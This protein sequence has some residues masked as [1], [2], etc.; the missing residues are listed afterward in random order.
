MLTHDKMFYAENGS[1]DYDDEDDDEDGTNGS[2]STV[3]TS[4]I[5]AAR[6]TESSSAASGGQASAPVACDE[7]HF[8]EKWFHGKLGSKTGESGR[9][10]AQQLLN[11][12]GPNLGDGTFLVRESE[13]FVG[14]YTL[15]FWRQGK[16]NHCRIR[17]K[18]ERGGQT[19]YYLIDTVLFDSLYGLI[20]HYQTHPLRSQEFHVCLKESVPQ[21]N[22][23]ENQ[24]WYHKSFNK[25]QAEDMLKRIKY[26]GAFLMRPSEAEESCFSISFRSDNQIKHC[27]IKQEGRLFIIGNSQFE[28]LVDLI[29]WYEKHPLYKKTKLS[30]PVNEN[31]VRRLGSE[32]DAQ[33]NPDQNYL[34][35]SNYIDS[36]SFSNHQMGRGGAPFTT[37]TSCCVKALY[38]YTANRD[39]ELSFPKHAIITNVI[40]KDE[41]WWQGDYGAKIRYW[42]PANFVQELTSCRSELTS[43]SVMTCDSES[44]GDSS[45]ALMPLG[46]LQKGTVDIVNCTVVPSNHPVRP[47]VFKIISQNT[48]S[49]IEISATSEDD[50]HDW[51]SKIRETSASASE[52]FKKGQKIER[53]LKI[54]KEFSQL[55]IY[56]RAVPFSPESEYDM[57][58]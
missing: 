2:S 52:T 42:F 39:D 9:V 6:G 55:I 27:R 48:G 44:S 38:D 23:H 40:K 53:D 49:S 20:T 35:S 32:P 10:V 22:S 4:L 30:Y 29:N 19:K 50:M 41:N 57:S 18:Q 46:T 34:T 24:E 58:L 31:T 1:R 56:C 47:H 28:S 43:S 17:T 21:P 11:R 15:S 54:A 25:L 33:N 3:M 12:Y 14:D 26:D 7:L 37:G 13:T 8:G 45:S 51:I 36:T 16:V 5:P